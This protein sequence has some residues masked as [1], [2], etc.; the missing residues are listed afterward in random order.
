MQQQEGEEE[1]EE[2][3][4]QPEQPADYNQGEPGGALVQEARKLM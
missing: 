4:G 3:I 1:E 2:D